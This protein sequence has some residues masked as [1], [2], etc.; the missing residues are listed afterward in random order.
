M[1][2]MIDPRWEVNLFSFDQDN[3]TL[4]QAAAE[5]GNL[6]ILEILHEKGL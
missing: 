6:G 1:E 2:E 3:R 4:M 5:N